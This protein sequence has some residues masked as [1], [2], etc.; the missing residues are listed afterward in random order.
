MKNRSFYLQ[1]HPT[2]RPINNCGHRRIRWSANW[3]DGAHLCHCHIIPQ[4]RSHD[5]S[6]AVHWWILCLGLWCHCRVLLG[7]W[8]RLIWTMRQP[9]SQ[10]HS[11]CLGLFHLVHSCSKLPQHS[12]ASWAVQQLHHSTIP[13]DRR[14]WVIGKHTSLRASFPFFPWKLA[15]NSLGFDI[16]STAWLMD[17]ELSSF[18]DLSDP[19]AVFNSRKGVVPLWSQVNVPL[20]D[21]HVYGQDI[22]LCVVKEACVFVCCMRGLFASYCANLVLSTANPNVFLFGSLWLFPVCLNY[23]LGLVFICSFLCFKC[24]LSIEAFFIGAFCC[25]RRLKHLTTVASKFCHIWMKWNMTACS[26][27]LRLSASSFEQFGW[28]CRLIALLCDEYFW[29]ECWNISRLSFRRKRNCWC[30]V[31]ILFYSA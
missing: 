22:W 26:R 5:L 30:R 6:V 15:L 3:A 14:L 10:R 7:F 12:H 25:V 16:T 27:S 31:F 18:L 21:V 11:L 20:L 13:D 29:E 8:M 19:P 2:K 24:E 4:K 17:V 23:I 9:E 28:S 1:R